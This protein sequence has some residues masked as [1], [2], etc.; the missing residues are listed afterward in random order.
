MTR[1]QFGIIF[2]L[3]ALIVCVG[4]LSSKLNKTGATDPT[5]LA[6][7]LSQKDNENSDDNKK[8]E[9]TLSTNEYFY[10]MRLNKEQND[11]RLEDEMQAVIDDPNSSQEN[12][13]IANN[14]LIEKANLKNLEGRVELDVKNK[15]YE[16]VL[17]M[18]DNSKVKVYVKVNDELTQENSAAIQKVVE[19]ITGL[20]E[21]TITSMK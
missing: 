20:N 9:E 21:I 7:V 4:I 8:A 16:D 11:A 18:I 12:K 2:T 1:K 10:S 19:D 3:M 5:D 15:G 14:Q 6:A 17:C 13:D